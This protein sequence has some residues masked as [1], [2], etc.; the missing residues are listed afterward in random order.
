MREV[1]AIR[2]KRPNETRGEPAR[3]AMPRLRGFDPEPFRS[4]LR[5]F[6]HRMGAAGECDDVVQ[7]AFVRAIEQ[8]PRGEPRAWLYHIALNVL[9][10]R[11]RRA[12]TVARELHHAA[13]F[14]ARPSDDPSTDAEKKDLASRAREIVATLSDSQRAALL[15]RVF[16]HFEYPEIG[17]VLECTAATA[18]QH[19]HLALKAV[20]NRLL[21]ND[22]DDDDEC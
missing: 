16:R 18:R 13:R 1:N 10:D 5:A 14:H 4:E 7:E 15:L 17:E 8:P 22:G 3:D 6:L 9:R 2:S 20:R 19:V 21:A 11:G 12:A